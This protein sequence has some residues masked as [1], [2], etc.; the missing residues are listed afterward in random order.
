MKTNRLRRCPLCGSRRLVR[1]GKPFRTRMGR[2]T[3][4]IPAVE[5]ESC[6]ACHEEFFDREANI[7]IDEHCFGKNKKRA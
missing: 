7:V 1:V 6:P 3:V 4:T 5:R 2:R